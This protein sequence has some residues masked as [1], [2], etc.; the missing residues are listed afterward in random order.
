MALC[1]SL[2]GCYGNIRVGALE[3]FKIGHETS[4]ILDYID[5]FSQN[6]LWPLRLHNLE[7]ASQSLVIFLTKTG[8]VLFLFVNLAGLITLMLEEMFL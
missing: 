2:L 5:H 8:N 7:T 3:E 1:S 6:N 4:Y